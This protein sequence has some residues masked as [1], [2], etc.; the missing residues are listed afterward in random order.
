MNYVLPINQALAYES[1]VPRALSGL[2]SVERFTRWS[3]PVSHK[4]GNRCG[5]DS[6][7]ICTKTALQPSEKMHSVVLQLIGLIEGYVDDPRVL[8]FIED[9][10]TSHRQTRSEGRESIVKALKTLLMF[11]DLPSMKIARFVKATGELKPISVA[12]MAEYSGLSLSRFERALEVLKLVG[13]F[14]SVPQYEKQLDKHGNVCFKGLP[15]IK[16]MSKW[17]FEVFGLDKTLT[18]VQQKKRSAKYKVSK[19]LS[20]QQ[21]R[22]AE[23]I[24]QAILRRD[25]KQAAKELKRSM[26]G[27][28][29]TANINKTV[30][31]VQDG[32]TSLIASMQAKSEASR[33]AKN[34]DFEEERKR[35]LQ[36][37]LA[38]DDDD[39]LMF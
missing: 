2:I 31:A 11:L 26:W 36:A 16:F 10:R 4:F 34:R 14:G 5:H 35:Q 39:D 20:R 6:G 13:L 37:L 7:A 8:P 38:G 17:L 22:L 23:Q 28:Q 18:T 27:G 32:F 30:K 33:E 24:Q 12:D 19:Q 3:K 21:K 15:S 25:R 9:V 1:P 29:S